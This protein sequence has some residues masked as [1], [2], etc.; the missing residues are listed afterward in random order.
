M[1]RTLQTSLFGEI[2]YNPQEIY[3]FEEGIPGF[4]NLKEFIFIK[5]EDSPF[6]V[7]HAVAED[8]YF[9]LID[10]FERY[11]KYEFSLSRSAREKLEVA[12]REDILCYAIVVLREPLT[13]STANLS[14]PIIINR[15]TRR[16]MQF[17]LEQ[18]PYS[19]RTPLFAVEK[20]AEQKAERR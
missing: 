18:S 1:T 11:G 3:I 7:M 2:T 8:M 13:D 15:E 12:E 14:A 5:V 20:T 17:M 16:G 19:I 9:F 4:S 6:T 10:P